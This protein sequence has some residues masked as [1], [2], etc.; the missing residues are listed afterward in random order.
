[1]KL[2]G[3]AYSKQQKLEIINNL[4]KAWEATPEL[5]IGQLIVN[6][7]YSGRSTES[8]ITRLF[9]IEDDDFIQEIMYFVTKQCK[10][11]IKKEK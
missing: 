8:D 6:A 1:M 7:I 11:N 3:R 5:R 4:Y 9:Y 2:K 10:N